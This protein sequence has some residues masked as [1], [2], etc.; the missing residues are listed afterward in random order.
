MDKL[1]SELSDEDKEVFGFD[2]RDLD[3]VE[4]LEAYV[5]V[6]LSYQVLFEN[7]LIGFRE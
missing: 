4:Y 1:W 2:I 6:R 3:W 5:Q 7:Q